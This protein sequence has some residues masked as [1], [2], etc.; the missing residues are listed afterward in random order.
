VKLKAQFTGR[1][2]ANEEWNGVVGST[3][4]DSIT[5]FYPLGTTN[6]VQNIRQ[7]YGTYQYEQNFDTNIHTIDFNNSNKQVIV[8][9]VNVGSTSGN[10][11]PVTSQPS[12][13]LFAVNV[14]GHLRWFSK[15]RIY[16]LSIYE[17]GAIVCNLIPVKNTSNVIGMYDTVSG[18]FFTNAGTGEFIAGPESQNQTLE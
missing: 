4:G 10:F 16:E 12:I 14:Q 3:A 2:T 18:T 11:A 17:D 15:S 1:F 8:D 5:S 9:N 13:S 7:S 6:F